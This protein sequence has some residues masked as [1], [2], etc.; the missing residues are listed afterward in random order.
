VKLLK[1]ALPK[2]GCRTHFSAFD[3]QQ[4]KLRIEMVNYF[5]IFL[6]ASIRD[7]RSPA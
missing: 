6:W 4:E 1:N 2:T 7:M 5:Q 3:L